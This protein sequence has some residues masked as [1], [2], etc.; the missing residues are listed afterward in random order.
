MHKEDTAE[1]L[2]C[3]GV[4]INDFIYKLVNLLVRIINNEKNTI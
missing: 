1:A 3:L 4:P 2:K